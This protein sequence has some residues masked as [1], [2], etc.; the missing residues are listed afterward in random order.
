MKPLQSIKNCIE[1]PYFHLVDRC[2]PTL[3]KDAMSYVIY[4]ETSKILLEDWQ[5]K[6]DSLADIKSITIGIPVNFDGESDED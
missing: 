4:H 6:L 3:L 5:K 1:C 2:K